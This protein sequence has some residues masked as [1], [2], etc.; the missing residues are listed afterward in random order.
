MLEE[1]DNYYYLQSQRVSILHHYEAAGVLKVLSSYLHCLQQIQII[2]MRDRIGRTPVYTNT[3][4][5]RST[6]LVV[7]QSTENISEF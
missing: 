2:T 5:D 7:V 3:L 6:W 4:I 1:G